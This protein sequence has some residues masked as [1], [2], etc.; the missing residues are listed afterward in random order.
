VARG[1][2]TRHRFF[3]HRGE[4]AI[5]WTL[6]DRVVTGAIV[7]MRS[8][9]QQKQIVRSAEFR[10]SPD[11]I[12]EIEEYL[13]ANPVRDGPTMVPFPRSKRSKRKFRLRGFRSQ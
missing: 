6:R 10:L 4:V 9:V 13:K 2:N 5:A 3:H 12:L 8:A 1:L 7:G 11:E